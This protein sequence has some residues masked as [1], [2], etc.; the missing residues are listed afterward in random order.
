VLLKG[1][2]QSLIE[3]ALIFAAVTAA[4]AAMGIYVRRSANAKLE[5]TAIGLNAVFVEVNSEGAISGAVRRDVPF[6]EE[7]SPP[8]PVNMAELNML[9]TLLNNGDFQNAIDLINQAND[10]LAAEDTAGAIYLLNQGLA[11]LNNIDFN[12]LKTALEQM[13]P[14][15]PGISEMKSGADAALAGI[16]SGNQGKNLLAQAEDLAA[17]AADLLAQANAAKTPEERDK[18]LQ[19]R[20]QVLQERDQALTDAANSLSDAANSLSNAKDLFNSGLDL[21]GDAGETP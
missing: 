7:P 10:A 13:D 17:Q 8:P 16:A 3:Y 6:V 5:R 14:D 21:L 19:E 4:V 15:Q 11:L 9:R 2:A 18:L 20:D 1:R 12:Q